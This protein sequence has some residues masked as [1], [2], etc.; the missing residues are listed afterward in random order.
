MNSFGTLF[1]DKIFS[2]TF[3]WHVPNSLTFPGFP[4]KWSPCAYYAQQSSQFGCQISKHVC[5]NV[6]QMSLHSYIV[7]LVQL[8]ITT[9]GSVQV[10]ITETIGRMSSS[11]RCVYTVYHDPLYLNAG[12]K[13]SAA[14]DNRMPREAVL[15][16]LL[17]LHRLIW[18]HET[19]ALWS[20]TQV[21]SF[22]FTC[23]LCA[24]KNVPPDFC[25]YLH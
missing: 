11:N 12:C 20:R 2:L 4:D 6:V 17:G 19:G 23:R 16:C 15:R 24:V 3:P 25:P 22:A 8:L 5:N 1:H 10:V 18:I 14:E 21:R 9:I 13:H 7:F